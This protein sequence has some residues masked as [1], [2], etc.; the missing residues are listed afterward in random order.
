MGLD[1][2]AVAAS[3]HAT[4]AGTPLHLEHRIFH[5]PTGPRLLFVEL[6]RRHVE[7]DSAAVYYPVRADAWTAIPLTV[8]EAILSCPDR[9]RPA[10]S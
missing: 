4:Q 1:S 6:G 2:V 3:Y 8:A 9:S 7:A 5:Q 10:L